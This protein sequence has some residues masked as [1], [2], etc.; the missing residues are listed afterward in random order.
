MGHDI[1]ESKSFKVVIVGGSIAGLSFALMLEKNGVDFVVL[2]SYKSIAPQAGASIGVLS[3][4]LRIL[5]QLGCC[6]S[7]LDKA[8]YPVDK[9]YFRDSRGQL[10]W[11]LED[12]ERDI[13]ERFV[14]LYYFPSYVSRIKTC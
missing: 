12:Y 3:N 4:G 14:T 13:G 1:M 9:I 6:Q 11:S 7:V 2:E 10:I 5:D 8:E